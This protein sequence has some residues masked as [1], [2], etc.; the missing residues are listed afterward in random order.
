MVILKK[1]YKNLQ[2][3]LSVLIKLLKRIDY[4]KKCVKLSRFSIKILMTHVRAI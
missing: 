3:I 4:I 2:T 1:N